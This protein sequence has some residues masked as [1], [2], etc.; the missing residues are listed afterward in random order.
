MYVYRSDCCQSFMWKMENQK[1][2]DGF[3]LHILWSLFDD[4]IGKSQEKKTKWN[5]R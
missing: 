5:M 3:D 2:E 1:K 4:R